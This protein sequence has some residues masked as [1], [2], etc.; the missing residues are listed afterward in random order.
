MDTI[1][2]IKTSKN[3]VVRGEGR[4]TSRKM[5]CREKGVA[6]TEASTTKKEVTTH[7]IFFATVNNF[8][9]LFNIEFLPPS[10]LATWLQWNGGMIFGSMKVLQHTWNLSLST[11]HIQSYSL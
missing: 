11:S 3:V 10:G 9:Y 2:I 6:K 5:L 8:L 4:E 7:R 1:D